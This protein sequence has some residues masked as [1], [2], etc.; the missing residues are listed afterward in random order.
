MASTTA[1][2]KIFTLPSELR[3]QILSYLLPTWLIIEPDG[4]S[5][6][7]Q[8]PPC[9]VS[10]TDWY[11]GHERVISGIWNHGEKFHTEIRLELNPFGFDFLNESGPLQQLPPLP[12]HEI[13]EFMIDLGGYEFPKMALRFRQNLLWL[14][15]LLRQ[16]QIHFKKLKIEILGSDYRS[17]WNELWDSTI[18]EPP[19]YDPDDADIFYN[20]DIIASQEGFK[21]TLAYLLTPLALIPV[22]TECS[23]TL[24]GSLKEN[25]D[26]VGLAKEY[27]ECIDGTSPFDESD[28]C[29]QRDLKHFEWMKTHPEGAS[30]QCECADC[31]EYFEEQDWFRRLRYWRADNLELPGLRP[32]DR[33]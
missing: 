33:W 11:P 17:S 19:E 16:H 21:S 10:P 2:S 23:I 4:W 31:K 30:S 13:K 6:T 14:C 1:P 26:A 22:A 7:A 29:F 9:G 28:W 18:S 5:S 32:G 27:E 12:Y 8:G 24:P 3:A 15:G 20:V 25:E